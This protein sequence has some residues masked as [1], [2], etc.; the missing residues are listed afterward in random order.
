MMKKV[1][2]SILK[3]IG[4]GLGILVVLVAVAVLAFNLIGDT[5]RDAVDP[6]SK[7]R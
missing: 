3:E 6:N 5:I 4:I 7:E 2:L 1:L